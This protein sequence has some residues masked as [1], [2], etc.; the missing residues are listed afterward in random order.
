MTLIYFQNVN[1][2]NNKTADLSFLCSV[3]QPD[4]FALNETWL[5]ESSTV[6]TDHP[7]LTDLYSS[8]NIIHKAASGGVLI[9]LRK[10]I[11]FIRLS[12]LESTSVFPD[13]STNP[14]I[15][16]LLPAQPHFPRPTVLACTYVSPTPSSFSPQVL[17]CINH[18]ISNRPANS[19]LLILGDFNAH[20]VAW[21]CSASSGYGR[22]LQENCIQP[23]KL[24]VLNNTFCYGRKTRPRSPRNAVIDL[25]LSSQSH[26]VSSMAVVA[27][28]ISSDH[29]ALLLSIPGS[30]FEKEIVHTV[31]NVR[32]ASNL[33]FE[34][35]LADPIAEWINAVEPIVSSPSSIAHARDFIN[36]IYNDLIRRIH[37]V[38]SATIGKITIRR[39][40]FEWAQSDDIFSCL[41][42]F[43]AAR[44]APTAVHTEAVKRFRS[45]LREAKKRAWRKFSAGVEEL[46][47]RGKV[48]WKQIKRAKCPSSYSLPPLQLP[49]P[50]PSLATSIEEKVELLAAHFAS[51]NNSA[52][53]HQSPHLQ[54]AQNLCA[55]LRSSQGQPCSSFS[56]AD[57][58]TTDEVR[59]YCKAL[60]IA[61]AAG[62]DDLHPFF[63]KYGG[64]HLYHALTLL[65]NTILSFGIVPDQMKCANVVPLFKG[66]SD[67]SL[68]ASY[69]PISLTSILAKVFEQAVRKRIGPFLHQLSNLQAGFMK[70]RSLL[71]QLH[72]VRAAML[73]TLSRNSD[74]PQPEDRN[75]DADSSSSTPPVLSSTSAFRP[76]IFLDIQKAFDSVWVDGLIWKLSV[77]FRFPLYLLRVL[78]SF[79][80]DRSLRVVYEGQTSSP[81]HISSGVPQGCILSPILFNFFFNDI[82]LC[83][84]K[85]DAGMFADD[86][87]FWPRLHGKKGLKVVNKTLA[88]LY[89]WSAHWGLHFNVKKCQYLLCRSDPK[90]AL[91]SHLTVY[92][93]HFPNLPALQEVRCFKYLG[94]HL[95]NDGTWDTHINNLSQS[96][97][98]IGSLI[99]RLS[100]N[101][102]N[103][104]VIYRNLIQQCIL[105]R[106]R[107]GWPIW[108]PGT[109]KTAWK[110]V[111]G[112][113][114][115]PLLQV[116]GLPTATDPA[117]LLSAYGFC[118]LQEYYKVDLA[119]FL[120]SL[121][122]PT[123][124]SSPGMDPYL[125]GLYQL[126]A[127]RS[128]TRYK[129]S[130]VFYLSHCLS[131]DW[132]CLCPKVGSN[133]SIAIPP[134]PEAQTGLGLLSIARP[135]CRARSHQ[136]RPIVRAA[137]HSI[138]QPHLS[139]L[140]AHF[141]S[142]RLAIKHSIRF[143]KP[144]PLIRFGTVSQA[145]ALLRF[146]LK[147][148]LLFSGLSSSC[149][150]ANECSLCNASSFTLSL[151]LPSALPVVFQQLHQVAQ[152]ADFRL[153]HH[154]LLQCPHPGISQARLDFVSSCIEAVPPTNF[155]HGQFPTMPEDARDTTI[156]MLLGL[157]DS[158][159]LSGPSLRKK[160]KAATLFLDTIQSALGLHDVAARLHRSRS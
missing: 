107:F 146:S 138:I 92:L 63:I 29:D 31:W 34:L 144:C 120:S 47:A 26:C 133:P 66:N 91:D 69:R 33:S 18:I 99:S 128:P 153:S 109:T 64:E 148:F 87:C 16:L 35:A 12:H 140:S 39:S 159:L 142:V 9:G 11:A 70:G 100:Q 41:Q 43:H 158:T 27:P 13:P 5:Q 97:T 58:V 114:I 82:L 75:S 28:L 74:L 72:R 54:S 121:F 25:C 126:F 113:L 88:K 10:E 139:L 98:W 102:S 78:Y 141:M 83:M 85:C 105:S 147:S 56:P 22:T 90:A 51:I 135:F 131:S 73:Q 160:W 24:T 101:P 38:A 104:I 95:S 76:F 149:R 71:H 108:S 52:P 59:E 86:V 4:L 46:G 96:C 68:P 77:Q 136:F 32:E 134:N 55:Q 3:L 89:T 111:H 151:P 103:S 116:S 1:S 94:V 156:I 53:P 150:L 62:A 21:G 115:Q 129:Q 61:K 20:H 145:R 6:L 17:S 112:L 60:N 80:T 118:E 81:H 65:F 57:L 79:L 130:I 157:E 143:Q 122:S 49:G 119:N 8:Y 30:F 132:R 48:N 124:S 45:S 127:L 23:G 123:P 117:K 110:K 93:P 14:I 36:V 106:I 42:A 152:G 2:V 19:D 44:G 155:V 125:G 154:L 40:K 137:L 84:H 67:P 50:V 37:D 15:C 7:D